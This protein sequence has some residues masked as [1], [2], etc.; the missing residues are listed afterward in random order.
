MYSSIHFTQH[1]LRKFVGGKGTVHYISMEE[2]MQTSVK[3]C[4]RAADECIY[5]QFNLDPIVHSNNSKYVRDLYVHE[6][7]LSCF[8]AIYFT[9]INRRSVSIVDVHLK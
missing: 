5:I 4:D 1:T 3:F 7:I 8:T 2:M 9:E 6:Y